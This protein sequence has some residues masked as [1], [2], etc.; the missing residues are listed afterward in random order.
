M[1]DQPLA[2]G[3]LGAIRVEA[4]GRAMKIAAPRQRALLALLL[5]DANR[6]VSSSTLIDGIWGE[7][8]PQH[9]ESALHIVICRL[10]HVLGPVAPLLARD[11]AGY[12]IEIATHELDVTRAE[13]H[14]VE[15]RRAL[16]AN[17][18]RRASA[19]FDA[20]LT[21]WTGAPLADVTTFPFYDAASR[22]LDQ[23]QL[24]LVESRNTAYLRCGRHLEVL[25]D[26]EKWIAANPWRERLRAHQMVALYRSGRQIEALAAY[27]DLRRLL[28]DDFGIDPHDDVRRLQSRILSGDPTLLDNG[29][30]PPTVPDVVLDDE[31]LD[32]DYESR[33]G[34]WTDVI[35]APRRA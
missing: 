11:S 21:C 6:T 1:I 12:R 3:V 25:P 31:S 8:P 17:D 22:R 23:F 32:I 33:R 28:L 14:A 4:G 19:A 26:I 27:D 18:P 30:L 16:D 35:T 15:A 29:Y 2:C 13:A 20:A 9:P 34:T 5:L 24:E 10:R 7:T